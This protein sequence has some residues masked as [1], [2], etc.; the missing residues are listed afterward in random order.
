V[1]VELF[2][3]VSP[4]FP[5]S[6]SNERAIHGI[7]ELV[8]ALPE[9]NRSVLTYMM[10]HMIRL[11]H[12]QQNIHGSKERPTKMVQVWSSVFLRPPWEQAM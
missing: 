3:N 5:E 7:A 6:T 8:K 12:L 2:F 1:S 10:E 11:C 9:H 4:F